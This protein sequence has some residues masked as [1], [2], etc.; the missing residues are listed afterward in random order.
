MINLDII[1]TAESGRPENSAGFWNQTYHFP[2]V[3][4]SPV[5]IMNLI[6]ENEETRAG[7]DDS[8]NVSS[9]NSSLDDAEREDTKDPGP[10]SHP[11]LLYTSD[12]ADE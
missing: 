2:G 12:A 6:D 1:H 9:N 4:D 3:S 7:A 8:I 10:G 5:I 11:C